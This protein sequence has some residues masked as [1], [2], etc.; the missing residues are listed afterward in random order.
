MRRIVFQLLA[1][2][3]LL[4]TAVGATRPHYGG[5]LRVTLQSAPTTLEFPASAPPADYWDA[6]RVLSLVADNLVKSDAQGRPQPAL[7]VAW[8]SDATAKHWQLSLRRGAKFH[9]GS[10]AS[11]A[12]IAQILGPLHSDW[13]V[14][15][16]GDSLIIESENPMPSLLAE[17]SLPRNL[18]LKRN[19]GGWPIGTGAFRVADWQPG[20]RL[21]LA[22]NEESWQGRP[23]VDAVEI[24]FG[25]S[26]RDQAIALDLGKTDVIEVAP[27]AAGT[28]GS[29]GLKS[30][31]SLPVELMALVF[32]ASSRAQDPRVREAL[33]LS[34]DRKPI[35][36]VLLKG[37]GEPAGSVLPNW[38]AGYSSVFPTQANAQL[39]RAVLAESRQPA[40][41]LTYDPRDPQAQLIAERI[42]LGARE[43]GLTLQVSLSGPEDIRLVRVTLPSPDPATSLREASR[44]LGLPPPTVRSNAV[45]DLYQA[46]RMLLDQ[47]VV[48][49]LFHLPL[50]SA[51]GRRVRDW[52]PDPTG[53]WRISDVWLE[54]D[55][56]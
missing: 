35:Q 25:K 42:A 7:A 43:I 37:A 26:Q 51:A 20:K 4:S 53:A 17:L 44:Q 47:H 34:I 18:I 54:A 23:F 45:E 14:R 22:A 19:A 1:A 11:P 56:R 28:N 50:A 8:Q 41:T 29:Q 52:D 10:V 9:D 12:A 21:Q 39:A 16:S 49:P 46:E 33:A 27:Q 6:A 2:I 31:S 40:L 48:I 38:L 32:P 5:T 15:A 36:S 3:S 30:S 13:S 24:E 55:S